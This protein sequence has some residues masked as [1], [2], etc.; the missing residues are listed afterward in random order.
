MVIFHSDS[1]FVSHHHTHVFLK[2]NAL[3]IHDMLVSNE[4]LYVM[5][6]CNDAIKLKEIKFRWFTSTKKYTRKYLKQIGTV[7]M[8]GC[9]G[10]TLWS[11]SHFLKEKIISSIVSTPSSWILIRHKRMTIQI[12]QRTGTSVYY[13]FQIFM[14]STRKTSA[15]IV[16]IIFSH[17]CSCILSGIFLLF[18]I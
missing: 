7:R 18:K 8:T 13:I 14:A 3:P 12:E 2:I 15:R 11:D 1:I 4:L 6:I 5:Y 9:Q 17:V 16:A 10:S